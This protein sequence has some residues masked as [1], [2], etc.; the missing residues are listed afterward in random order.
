[1]TTDTGDKPAARRPETGWS[2]ARRLR[3]HVAP[4]TWIPAVE[5]GDPPRT[6]QPGPDPHIVRGED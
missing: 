2:T 1:V 4:R 6:P 5:D 3:G